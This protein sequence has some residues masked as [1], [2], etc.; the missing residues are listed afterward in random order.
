MSEVL[1]RDV[2]KSGTG[3]TLIVHAVQDCR[4]KHCVIHNPSAHHM[5]SWPTHWR[6]DRYLMERLCPHGIGHPD[7]DHI[8]FLPMERRSLE[9][10]HGCDGCCE[11]PH[12]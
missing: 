6:E 10:T 1:I 5:L 9:S 2:Y 11:V 3:Q 4:G 8:A 12:D 7:P